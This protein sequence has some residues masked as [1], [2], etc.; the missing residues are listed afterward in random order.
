MKLRMHNNS[1]QAYILHSLAVAPPL[2]FPPKEASKPSFFSQHPL[3]SSIFQQRSPTYT[4]T[5]G[6]HHHHLGKRRK[7]SLFPCRKNKNGRRRHSEK[8]AATLPGRVHVHSLKG[9]QHKTCLGSTHMCVCCLKK[10]ERGA[11]SGLSTYTWMRPF[12]FSSGGKTRFA[13]LVRFRRKA[14][15][16]FIRPERLRSRLRLQGAARDA[17]KI[18]IVPKHDESYSPAA[19]KM[20]FWHIH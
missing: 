16:F 8:K 11:T 6:S 7:R 13:A 5:K 3:P 2:S 19:I 4:W 10:R 18:Q 17:V 12:C 14:F 9:R 20:L 1:P 15:F